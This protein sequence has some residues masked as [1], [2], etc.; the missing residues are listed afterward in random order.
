[1][2]PETLPTMPIIRTPASTPLLGGEEVMAAERL[3][4]GSLSVALFAV[5]PADVS[6][7]SELVLPEPAFS[8]LM[9]SSPED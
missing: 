5:G 9:V 4:L 2:K 6:V 7:P 3:E 8:A 1:M